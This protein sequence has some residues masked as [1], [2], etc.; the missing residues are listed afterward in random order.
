MCER[1]DCLPVTTSN[2][3]GRGAL[4][5]SQGEEP[6]HLSNSRAGSAIGEGVVEEISRVGT[7][8]T[9]NPDIGR[10]KAVLQ[11]IADRGA[12]SSLSYC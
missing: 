11:S 9:L 6:L 12:E 2:N 5:V 4:G 7:A 10:P 3:L 8:N 1:G